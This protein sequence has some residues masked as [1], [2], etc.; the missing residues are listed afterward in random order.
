MACLY[1]HISLII[2][3]NSIFTRQVDDNP[4]TGPDKST[5]KI[6][7][8]KRTNLSTNLY[9]PSTTAQTFLDFEC[10]ELKQAVPTVPIFMYHSETG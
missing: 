5:R 10:L 2:I 7:V 4:T 1:T 8:D 9:L 6:L 3:R